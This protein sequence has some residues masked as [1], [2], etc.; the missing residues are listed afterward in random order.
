MCKCKA[1]IKAIDAYIA[2]AD[3]NLSSALDDAG[4]IKPKATVKKINSLEDR[5][6]SELEKETKYFKSKAKNA[7]DLKSFAKEFPSLI[8][9]DTTDS[10]LSELF[11][12]D[13]KENIPGLA[14]GY[15]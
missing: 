4:F 8:D 14:A 12:K 10:R 6:T 1:L 5:L 3:D 7:V 9:E 15:I 11:V 2:K 13:F